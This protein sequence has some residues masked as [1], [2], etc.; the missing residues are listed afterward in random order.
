[1]FILYELQFKKEFSVSPGQLHIPGCDWE[2]CP[3]CK[4]QSISCGCGDEE[5]G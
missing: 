5:E 3:K 2:R 1:M 4:G